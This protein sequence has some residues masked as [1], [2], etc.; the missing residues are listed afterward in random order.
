MLFKLLTALFL[1]FS[2]KVS[3][4]D[5]FVKCQAAKNNTYEIEWEVPESISS[6][7]YYI[8]SDDNW[9]SL[10]PLE[11]AEAFMRSSHFST[12]LI[13]FTNQSSIHLRTKSYLRIIGEESNGRFLDI[14]PLLYF[15]NQSDHALHDTLISKGR[16]AK[17]SKE[18][19]LSEIEPYLLPKKHSAHPILEEIF[20][21]KGVL[22][23]IETMQD[24]GFNILIHRQG[25][26]LIL[27]S[28]PLL[29]G[30]LIKTY[31]D[32]GNFVEWT[33]W[34][35]RA[36]GRER[37]QKFLDEH[38]QYSACMKVPKK[39]IF[40]IPKKG[41]GDSKKDSIARKYILLVE[42][43]KLVSKIKNEK[44]YKE[45]I[46][47]QAL[48]GLYLI[49]D[50]TG[51]SDGH[52]GNVPFSKDRRIAFIDTEYTHSWPVHFNWLTK[53]F[54]PSKQSYWEYLIEN[55]GPSLAEELKRKRSS[56]N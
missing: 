42:D 38:P 4:S 27:A 21:V 1:S 2:L 37:M 34:V 23:S 54:S 50:E 20:A 6:K 41:I 26:G 51:F 47:Y 10:L 12:S 45:A 14:A 32:T 43:M 8:F 13:G 44:L 7:A 48:D 31:L 3:A 28:H 29:P 39:W 16:S 15:K 56:A 19:K 30:F 5:F 40:K 25:R 24:A 49:I 22:S 55:Q 9:E 35:R 52:I 33:R 46:T 36:K 11:S 53:W 18:K 17:E